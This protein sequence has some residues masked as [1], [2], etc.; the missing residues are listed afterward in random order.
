MSRILFASAL[1]APSVARAH[2]GPL[3]V[4][5]TGILLHSVSNANHVLALIAALTLPVAAAVL[6]KSRRK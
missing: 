4:D 1:I 5:A 2:V 3:G 6:I